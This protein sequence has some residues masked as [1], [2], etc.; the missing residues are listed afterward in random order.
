MVWLGESY[1]HLMLMQEFAAK[2]I[3]VESEMKLPWVL[4]T[5][6]P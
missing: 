6:I 3:F 1:A 2:M 5:R 4:D